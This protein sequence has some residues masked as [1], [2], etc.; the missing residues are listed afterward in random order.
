MPTNMRGLALSQLKDLNLTNE[1]A[2][3]YEPSGEY[4][5][6]ADPFL[7]RNGEVDST[8]VKLK[9]VKHQ[10]IC[11]YRLQV[12]ITS[13]CDIKTRNCPYSGVQLKRYAFEGWLQRTNESVN[14][15]HQNC[16]K[17]Q[18]I[19]DSWSCEKDYKLLLY[20]DCMENIQNIN[21]N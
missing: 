14:I 17:L 5:Y 6:N 10:S 3:D 21:Y 12:H 13:L 19:T 16:A 2:R 11:Q 7:E 8:L 9:I 15:I 1:W 20:L 4:N 18:V